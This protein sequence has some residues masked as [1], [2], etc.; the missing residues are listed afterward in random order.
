MGPP[1]SKHRLLKRTLRVVLLPLYLLFLSPFVAEAQAWE[2]LKGQHF[3]IHFIGNEEFARDVLRKAEEDY[4]RI[5]LEINSQKS[6]EFWTWEN[7]IKI[8]IYPNKASFST[9]TKQ[10]WWVSAVTSFRD[11]TI[12]SYEGK[13]FLDSDLS[14]EVA[15]LIFRDLVGF[16]G[17]VPLWLDEGVA[18]WMEGEKTR[19]MANEKLKS[20]K[21]K[22]LIS[23]ETMARLDIHRVKDS[24]LVNIFYG[25]ACSLVGFL[26]ERY[27]T[28]NFTKFYRQLRDEKKMDEALRFAYPTTFRSV[29]ELDTKW[30]EY[31][32]ER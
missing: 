30:K 1:I 10:P 26:I 29:A 16:K 28:E 32:A 12:S 25:E 15:H 13:K 6:L 5:P 21:E 8:Y 27:G 23:I 4:Q 9:L 20:L 31:L 19:S 11:R 14:H 2:L 22:E 24:E 17:D 18:Q 7:R 3:I